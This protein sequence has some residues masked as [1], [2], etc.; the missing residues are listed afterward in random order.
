M[1]RRVTLR[2]RIDVPTVLWDQLKREAAWLAISPHTY[3]SLLLS[4]LLNQPT[5]PPALDEQATRRYER[6]AR[7]AADMAG[8]ARRK[9]IL[10][11]LKALPDTAPLTIDRE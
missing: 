10:A 2:S 6:L 8:I 7:M 5:E 11:Q 1:P 4:G 3:A 9:N